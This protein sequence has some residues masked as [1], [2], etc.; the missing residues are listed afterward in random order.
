MYFKLVNHRNSHGV[1]SMLQ[2]FYPLARHLEAV[3]GEKYPELLE[4]GVEGTEAYAKLYQGGRLIATQTSKIDETNPYSQRPQKL[5]DRE[6]KY[7]VY[8]LL[9]L[10]TGQSSP[11][12]LLTGIRPVKLVRETRALNSE[13]KTHEFLTQVAC[14]SEKKAQTALQ[15]YRNQ[16]EI[17]SQNRA[18]DFNLYIGIPFC[19][20]KCVYCSFA[21]Y[22]MNGEKCRR[23]VEALLHEMT[24]VADKMKGRGI[25]SVYFGGGT[26]T[27]LAPEDLERVLSNLT[28]YFDLSNIREFTVEAGR[29]DTINGEKLAILKKYQVTR[30]SI[31]PQ[32]T[33]Q[34]TLDTIGRHH[35]VEDFYAAFALSRS[36]GFDNI[37]T[38]VILGLTG[39]TP[40]D[41][42]KTMSDLVKLSPENIT[43]HTLAIK[44][45][46]RLKEVLEEHQLAQ[47]R[48]IEKM[49]EIVERYMADGY[50]PYYLYRNKNTLGNVENI[51]YGKAGFFSQYNIQ[52]MED[53]QDIVALGCASVSKY[54]DG[55]K[56]TRKSHPRDVDE[57]IRRIHGNY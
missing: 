50:E 31:N 21:A 34:A 41:V 52:M 11:W 24:I 23:Y 12:G 4:S 45:A 2:I 55:T 6:I 48:D 8:Q 19:P 40:E 49:Q 18:G 43:V 3:E 22:A 47:A 20:T 5:I 13:V 14:V 37:N 39:E 25:N 10:H 57:Y 44:R 32:T 7:T 33:K 28:K 36:M 56:I 38:D 42:E 9:S 46:S 51:G 1:E 17:L 16:T 53:T 29:P 30:I 26:P 27:S 54:L 15:I 35:T